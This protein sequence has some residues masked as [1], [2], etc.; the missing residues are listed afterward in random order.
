[1]AD[2]AGMPDLHCSTAWCRLRAGRLAF[3]VAAMITFEF[4]WLYGLDQLFSQH[5]RL[6]SRGRRVRQI[7]RWILQQLLEHV[8]QEVASTLALDTVMIVGRG[9]ALTSLACET[10]LNTLVL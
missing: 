6:T 5:R 3:K 10:S 8:L 9:D 2:P 7:G 1:M 4:L